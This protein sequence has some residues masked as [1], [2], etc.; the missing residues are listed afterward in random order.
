MEWSGIP[1]GTGVLSI[2]A[3]SLPDGRY[4]FMEFGALD[5]HDQL[6]EPNS[7][8]IAATT[9]GSDDGAKNVFLEELLRTN[10]EAFGIVLMSGV[11]NLLSCAYS[12]SRDELVSL[13]VECIDAAGSWGLEPLE[14]LEQLVE[15]ETDENDEYSLRATVASYLDKVLGPEEDVHGERPSQS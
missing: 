9:P 14:S 15:L 7:R 11:P 12:R 3:I 2:D 13:F 8:V 4:V 1:G 10:G 5:L 6:S